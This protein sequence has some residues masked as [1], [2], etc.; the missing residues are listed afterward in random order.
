VRVHHKFFFFYFFVFGHKKTKKTK[1]SK[2]IIKIMTHVDVNWCA[3][4]T[5]IP[6]DPIVTD[7]ILSTSTAWKPTNQCSSPTM[8]QRISNLFLGRK[9]I[10]GGSIKTNGTSISVLTRNYKKKSI[11]CIHL[12]QSRQIHRVEIFWGAFPKS[13]VMRR[14]HGLYPPKEISKPLEIGGDGSGNSHQVS[15]VILPTVQQSTVYPSQNFI[16]RL[17]MGYETEG[18]VSTYIIPRQL[19]KNVLTL[20]LH[21]IQNFFQGGMFIRQIKVIPLL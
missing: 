9:E 1:K 17:R 6:F 8:C 3:S 4:K 2:Y 10:G 20:T 18:S 11:P 13:H 12:G 5:T 7:G 21:D 15:H 14:R 16:S 19:S